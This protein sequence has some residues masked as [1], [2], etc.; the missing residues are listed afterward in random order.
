MFRRGNPLWLPLRFV[1]A[2]LP[3]RTIIM[4]N[5]SPITLSE[6]DKKRILTLQAEIG[7]FCQTDD[8]ERRKFLKTKQLNHFF[9]NCQETIDLLISISDDLEQLASMYVAMLE[10]ST[11][12]ESELIQK[13][14]DISKLME[15]MKKYL[16]SQLIKLI[17]GG[18]MEVK[19][20]TYQRTKLTI[21]FSD[22]VGFTDAT[23]TLDPES[24]SYIL[25]SYL[26]EMAKIAIKWGGTI[27]K[28]IGDA[29]MVF[30]GD[31]EDMDDKTAAKNC[32][33]MALEMQM[34]MGK[35]RKKLHDK[36]I[37]YSFQVRIG[38]NSGYCTLGNFG[39]EE[40]MDYT[41][42]GSNVNIAARLEK[43]CPHASILVSAST[44]VYVKDIVY[45]IPKDKIQVKGVSHPIETYEVL[46][47]LTEDE[48][49]PFISIYENS[50]NLEA[51]YYEPGKTSTT[52]QEK[53]KKSLVKALNLLEKNSDCN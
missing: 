32:V 21:F 29:I 6:Q 43:R 34:S 9:D 5:E 2:W 15:K 44:Y 28:F 48:P 1:G 13:N 10:H 47:L 39:S 41:P 53:I 19:A 11:A 3:L 45:A 23:D 7:K 26:D 22:I 36:G 46:C 30:F 4:N 17:V 18:K 24:L 50:F 52:D 37:H 20:G 42:V 25:N 38:I 49:S 14:E 31:S 33:L 16:S 27:D 8:S 12:L 35:L 40:R 51:I